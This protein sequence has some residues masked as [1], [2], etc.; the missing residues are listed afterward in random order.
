VA[1]G[2]TGMGKVHAVYHLHRSFWFLWRWRVERDGREIKS[3]IA[4][5]RAVARWEAR[6][7]LRR[8]GKAKRLN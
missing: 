6:S 3:G 1:A 5:S 4:W 8:M 2:Q 7:V